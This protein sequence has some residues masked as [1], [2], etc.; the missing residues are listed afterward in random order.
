M[1]STKKELRE[2]VEELEMRVFGLE[3]RLAYLER[4]EMRRRKKMDFPD[5]NVLPELEPR[6]E[7]SVDSGEM[8]DD[9]LGDA[10][11]IVMECGQ[12]SFS[13]LQIG[14]RVGYARLA[15]LV[16]IMEKRGYIGGFDSSKPLEILITRAQY[17]QIFMKKST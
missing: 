6:V 7:T 9:L 8:E 16:N 12:V 1:D 10:M 2:L 17:E 5:D 13:I 4:L 11:R 14:L 3:K 15:Q